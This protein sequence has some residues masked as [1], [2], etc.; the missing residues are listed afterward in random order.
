MSINITLKPS[1]EIPLVG[2]VG[3]NAQTAFISGRI[4]VP[5]RVNGIVIV[6]GDDHVDNV[7]HY[8]LTDDTQNISTT[9]ISTGDHLI[10]ISY[11][12]R[13]F[14]GHSMIRRVHIIREFP[15]GGLILKCHVVN[16]NAYQITV[17]AAIVVEEI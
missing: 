11:P 8:F 13:Y 1:Y 7:L 5:F 16:N 15:E 10:P 12:N 14:I 6:F 3:A 4:T 2:V 9:S 17:N